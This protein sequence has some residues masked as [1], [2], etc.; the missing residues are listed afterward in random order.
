[1]LH[2]ALLLLP[3]LALLGLG[4]ASALRPRNYRP[5]PGSGRGMPSPGKRLRGLGELFNERES[6]SDKAEEELAP[7][8]YGGGKLLTDPLK[9][10]LIFYGKWG[11]KSDGADIII[12]FIK[13]MS[14]TTVPAPSVA[15]WWNIS[16]AYYMTGPK[17]EKEY[18][19]PKVR[20]RHQRRFSEAAA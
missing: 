1:M 12:N 13:S 11:K 3:F 19:S 20:R 17:G 4:C 16:T 15:K 9:I 8:K 2:R 7:I 5:E 6:E 14:D 10:Y 18:V